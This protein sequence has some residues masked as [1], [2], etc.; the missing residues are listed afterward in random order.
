MF[1][2]I[3]LGNS[4]QYTQP[5]PAE[6]TIVNGLIIR[7]NL[8]ENLVLGQ[9]DVLECIPIT[10]QFGSNINYFSSKDSNWIE[11]KNGQNKELTL[12][13]VDQ[14]FNP[15]NINVPNILISLLIKFPNN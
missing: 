10:S 3:S 9:P 12:N 14:N 13:I 1:T 2:P 6:A 4:L 5:F 11:L 7:S 15:I 8:V